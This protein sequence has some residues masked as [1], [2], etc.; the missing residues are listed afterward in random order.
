[1]LRRVCTVALGVWLMVS[2]YVLHFNGAPYTTAHVVGPVV[3]VI[4]VVSLRDVTRSFR[5]VGLLPVLW[6]MLA[7]W[8]LH[9]H[10]GVPLANEELV[11]IALT[12]QTVLPGRTRQR[13]GGG[14]LALL[15]VRF[16]HGIFS[17][18]AQMMRTQ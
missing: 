2:P 16:P 18:V 3:I 4:G 15:A 12:I 14:W 7:P 10:S 17:M 11:G 1:M 13:T 9:V 5:F 6:L 8:F